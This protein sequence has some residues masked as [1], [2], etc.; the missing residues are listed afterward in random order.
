[1]QNL[2]PLPMSPA[3]EIRMYRSGEGAR[4]SA[5]LQVLPGNSYFFKNHRVDGSGISP[6]GGKESAGQILL[7]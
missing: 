2:F 4:K 1:M 7:E 5:F 6:F 3:L